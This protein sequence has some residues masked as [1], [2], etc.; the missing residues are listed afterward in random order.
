MCALC[1]CEGTGARSCQR[2]P[3]STCAS[4]QVRGDAHL[5]LLHLRGGGLGLPRL[6]LRIVVP[7]R[8]QRHADAQSACE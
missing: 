3:T 5:G 2:A 4:S 7:A 8:S 1:A 6:E